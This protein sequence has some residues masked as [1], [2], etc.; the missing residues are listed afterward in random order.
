VNAPRSGS[1]RPVGLAGL[2]WGSVLLTAG[3]RLFRVVQGREP[4]RGEQD[5]LV[6][7]GARHLAQGLLQVVLPHHLAGVH[8]VV[9]GLHAASM[10]ALAA[11][12]PGRRRAALVSGAVAALAGVV[13]L[14]RRHS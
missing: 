8:A 5:A 4:S 11:V 14:R 2:A 10:V 9:D 13:V 3:P 6:L 12:T 1:L 7:L